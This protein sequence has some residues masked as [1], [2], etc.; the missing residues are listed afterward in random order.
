V[1]GASTT[2]VTP[3]PDCDHRETAIHKEM[4]RKGN[5][6]IEKDVHR[7]VRGAGLQ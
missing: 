7:A 5:T 3:S 1:P 2:T 6:V 4:D